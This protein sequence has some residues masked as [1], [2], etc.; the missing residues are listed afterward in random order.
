MRVQYGIF[1]LDGTLLDS[2][3]IWEHAADRFLAAHGRQAPEDLLEILKPMSLTETAEYLNQTFGL[4]QT[5]RETMEE[6]KADVAEEYDLRA[7]LKPGVEAFLRELRRRGARLCV[8]TAS[9][10]EHVEAALRRVGIRRYFEGIVTCTG[11]GEGKTGPRVFLEAARLIGAP[12]PGAA[13]V[14][15]D[16][17]H[18]AATAKRAGFQVVAVEDPSAAA[19]RDELR[20]VCDLYLP[21]FLE[22]EWE[23]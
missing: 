18:A 8:A 12:E 9:E 10:E 13:V 6:I 11:V 3:Y 17:A 16:A 15:E 7:P 5:T 22:W 19:D 23:E 14:F 20:R 21:S 4:N 2:M 1:D